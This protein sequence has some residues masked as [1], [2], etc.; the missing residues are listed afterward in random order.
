VPT[1]L[2]LRTCLVLFAA[3]LLAMPQVS[4]HCKHGYD[5]GS[6]D[7]VD[8][9]PSS[10]SGL[11]LAAISNLAFV[12]LSFLS[13]MSLDT[14]AI[15]Q[16]KGQTEAEQTLHNPCGYVFP[17]GGLQFVPAPRDEPQ[18]PAAQRGRV[19]DGLADIVSDAVSGAGFL[20]ACW[21]KIKDR[22]GV[23]GRA[24]SFG[25]DRH[26]GGTLHAMFVTL[27]C[28]WTVR[29]DLGWSGVRPSMFVTNPSGPWRTEAGG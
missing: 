15:K 26:R 1:W 8:I 20:K 21:D 2:L 18:Q 9:L 24:T 16:R 25:L 6:P 7:P 10:C 12:V 14:P 22:F 17:Y 29:S 5:Y 4:Y 13:P 27:T 23:A 3:L 19:G 11:C 28:W